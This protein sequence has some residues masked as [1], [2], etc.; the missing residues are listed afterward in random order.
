M[1]RI[2]FVWIFLTGSACAQNTFNISGTIKDNVE[3]IAGANVYIGGYKIS[4]LTNANGKFTLNNLKPGNYDILVQMIGYLPFSKNV[5][6]T[7]KSVAVELI[8]T[9]STTKLNEVVIRPN[10]NRDYLMNMFRDFFIGKT[11]NASRCKI[12]N[13]NVIDIEEDQKNRSFTVKASDFILVDN[14]ALGYRIKY[15]LENFEYSF[16]T[17]VLFYAGYATFEDMKGSK[18]QHQKWIK[19]RDL[20]YKGSAQHFFTSLYQNNADE[21]GFTI[22]KRIEIP[23]KERLPDSLIEA[24]IK[25]LMMG[26]VKTLSIENKNGNSI[27]YWLREKRKPKNLLVIDRNKVLTDTLVKIFNPNFKMINY[28]DDLFVAYKNEK[29]SS[30]YETSSFYQSRPKYITGQVSVIKMLRA[31]VYFY[32]NGVVYNPRS[33]LYSGYWSY[34]KMADTVPMDYIIGSSTK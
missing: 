15:L 9:A 28:K 31:P 14:E 32:Q 26:G 30:E 16:S 5:I 11:V 3:V 29:E 4:T 34:E 23:N 20:A 2:L 17:R 27:D 21:E 18:S 7:D 6:I 8:L 33:T 24:N 22:L 12:L 10:P 25:Q 1:F 13:T 19:N